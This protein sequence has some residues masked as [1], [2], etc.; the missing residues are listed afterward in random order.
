M[1]FPKFSNVR[2]FSPCCAQQKLCFQKAL[3]CISF[4][5]STMAHFFLPTISRRCSLI[6][7]PSLRFSEDALRPMPFLPVFEGFFGIYFGFLFWGITA[8]HGAYD[9]QTLPF[10]PSTWMKHSRVKDPIYKETWEVVCTTTFIF[11]KSKPEMRTPALLIC[12]AVT[13]TGDPWRP[14]WMCL[15]LMSKQ[16]SAHML[17]KFSN[18]FTSELRHFWQSRMYLPCWQRMRWSLGQSGQSGW[19]VPKFCLWN[20]PMKGKHISKRPKKDFAPQARCQHQALCYSRECGGAS[21][22]SPTKRPQL[23]YFAPK[24]VAYTWNHHTWNRCGIG[25]RQASFCKPNF[26]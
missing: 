19:H 23:K 20:L 6:A 21:L 24:C 2:I 25:E 26:F 4:N 12:L 1:V 18:I 3:H 16:T 10:T 22:P 5:G 14:V 11:E 15:A 7:F 17:S 8:A 9:V 13:V